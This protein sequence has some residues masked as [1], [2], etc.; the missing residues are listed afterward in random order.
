MAYGA[1]FFTGIFIATLVYYVWLAIQ[2]HKARF[3]L[4][5]DLWSCLVWD[6]ATPVFI[7]SGV[8]SIVFWF[9]HFAC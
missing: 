6:K 8:G 5:P 2:W 9:L 3:G 4:R 1:I 7:A